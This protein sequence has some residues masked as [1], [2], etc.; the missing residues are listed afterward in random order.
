MTMRTGGIRLDFQ[1][2]S[3]K[4]IQISGIRQFTELMKRYPDA[5]SL[6]I[7][8]PHL[9]T[10]MHIRHAAIQAIEQGNT[11]YTNNRGLE[12][13]RQAASC[14][15]EPQLQY[16]YHPER[17]ILVT[18]G[19]TQALDMALRTLLQAGDEVIL[20]GPVYPGY[21]PIIRMLGAIPIVIDTRATGFI[22][23][24]GQL[25]EHLSHRT[26]VVLLASP[27]NPTGVAYSQAN[28]AALADVLREKD[29]YVIADELYSE[30]HFEGVHPSFSTYPGMRAKTIVI[31]GLSKSHSMTGWRIGFTFA[32][33]VIT[34]E[35]VKVLQYSV[36]CASTISQYAALEALEHGQDDAAPMR[37]MY[38]HHRNLVVAKC[39]ELGLPLVTPDGAF[40]AFP[41][42]QST[43]LS[44]QDFARRLLAEGGVAMVPG[45]AFGEYGE[46]HVRLSYACDETVLC[47]GLERLTRYIHRLHEAPVSG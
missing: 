1:P 28:Y 18:V 12:R 45:D 34:A 8:Q 27:S 42:I 36:T 13:L 5:V 47:E 7:G 22:M 46:G 14:Y 38:R 37:D 3:T 16:K 2:I 43:G 26:K 32:P 23:T 24:P 41:D 17:E 9:P 30:L 21:E 44:S 15:Y 29:I 20:P 4:Q 19:A 31:Q 25:L 39:R 33:A 11:G 10:P 40:Y 35:M 6:T